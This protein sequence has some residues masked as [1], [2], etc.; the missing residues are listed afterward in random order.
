MMTDMNTKTSPV[1]FT[2]CINITLLV[3][4]MYM[5][6]VFCF[7]ENILILDLR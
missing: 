2:L 5:K 6:V 3:R 4:F 1:K 7:T